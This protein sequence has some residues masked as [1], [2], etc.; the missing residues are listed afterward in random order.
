MKK[1]LIATTNPGKIMTAKKILEWLGVEGVSFSDLGISLNEPEETKATA[2][3]IAVEKALGYARQFKDF[4]VLARDDTNF[5]V[6]VSEEDDP[7]NHNKEFVARKAGEYT[8][9]NGIKVFSEL[10][11][12]YGGEIPCGFDWG[13]A[14]AWHDGDE[15]RVVSGLATTGTEKTKIV[16]EASPARVPGFCFAPVMKVLVNGEW[17]YDAELTDKESWE[18]YWNLQAEMIRGLIEKCPVL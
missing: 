15:V 5:L 16:S 14:L 3:E 1:I 6:G 9:E 18:A 8:D 11:G 17:K 10:A 13:Y 4:P 7:K 12:K 2:E